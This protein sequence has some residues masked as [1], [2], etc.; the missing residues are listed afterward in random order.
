MGKI[1]FKNLTSP[2]FVRP[3]HCLFI[4]FWLLLCLVAPV[5]N[6][7]KQA[8]LLDVKGAMGPA[9]KD[10]ILRGLETAKEKK[11]TLVVLRLDTPGGLDSSM[12]EI[13][14][15]IL[16]SD[17]PVATFVA[18]SGARAASAGTFILY[19]SHIAAM[20]PGTNLG[21]A[22]PVNIGGG[23][24]PNP[25]QGEGNKQD[26]NAS[27]LEKKVTFDAIA[28][29]R[30]LAEL[31][32]RNVDF[33]ENA[34]KNAYSLPAEEALKLHVIDFLA[35]DIPDLL[36][37]ING[38]TVKVQN[39]LE[40]LQTQD[41]TVE[42]LN[43]NW[44]EQIL[45]VIT[46]PNIAYILLLLG[47]YGIFFEFANPGFILPGVVGAIAI[48]LALYAFQL[49]PINFA[50]FALLFLGL[51]FMILEAFITSF[52]ILGIGG[53]I[54]FA[55]GSL[56]LLNTEVPGFTIAW[57]VILLMSII[58]AGFFLVLINLAIQSFRRKV[59]TGQEAL[60]GLEG[61]ILE[62]SEAVSHVPL[63]Q[64][65]KESYSQ[66]IYLV[67]IKG[68]IWKAQC[69]KPLVPGQKVRVIRVNQLLLTVEPVQEST[70]TETNSTNREKK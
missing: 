56:L 65:R 39:R 62:Y 17:I 6:A 68:E 70:Q 58:T 41:L 27:T 43:S 36:H 21:A 22:S 37:Q 26:Q 49:L 48:L 46:D 54:A 51:I 4:F 66:N 47:I 28:Y 12:R 2:S 60:M 34:V 63:E 67:K 15:A 3:C 30:S 42:T 64:A 57:Q 19:A 50:G 8:I 1:N 20:A 29:I 25:G 69:E 61:Q 9:T 10:Y 14:K 45:T 24:L 32:N 31:R 33:A 38:K 7:S 44:R 5:A 55:A 53:V 52:G 11:A 40:T 59:V 18:P 23:M 16:A 13:N 35:S